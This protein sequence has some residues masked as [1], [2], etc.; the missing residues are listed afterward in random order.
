MSR[1]IDQW[2]CFAS[3]IICVW[4]CWCFCRGQASVPYLEMLETWI[5]HGDLIDQYGELII[6]SCDKNPSYLFLYAYVC[7]PMY[8]YLVFCRSLPLYYGTSVY[9]SLSLALYTSVSLL[10][11]FFFCRRTWYV[12]FFIP[13]HCLPKGAVQYSTIPFH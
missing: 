13:F 8:R 3:C 1:L 6:L 5:Y 7:R 11:Y 9:L 12:F 10:F 4:V 2:E